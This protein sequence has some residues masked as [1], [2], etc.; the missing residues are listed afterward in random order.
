MNTMEL[1][2]IVGALCGA[3]LIFMLV[4]WAAEELYHTGGGHGHGD[5]HMAGY[6]IEV[7][8][9]SASAEVEEGP[10]LEEMMAA[11]NIEKGAKVF[12]KCKACHKLEE[13]ANGTGP[14]LY[15]VVDRAIGG[16]DGFGYSGA[17]AGL[18]GNWDY[19]ALDGFLAKPSKYAPGTSMGFAGLKKPMD[20]ANLIMYL[21]SLVK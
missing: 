19:A 17:L 7:E 18:G 13:G 4:T 21:E 1:T 12:N 9:E 15:G 16:M 20:R 5:E 11:A 3:L 2:K 6:V 14:S 10:S 8:E